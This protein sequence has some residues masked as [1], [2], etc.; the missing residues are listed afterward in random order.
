MLLYTFLVISF[1]QYKE[2][3]TLLISFCNVPDAL[4]AFVMQEIL[5]IFEAFA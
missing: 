2:Y 5:V 1:S 4:P 3:M